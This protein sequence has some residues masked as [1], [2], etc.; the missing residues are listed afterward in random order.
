MAEAL[1]AAT[2]LSNLSDEELMRAEREIA[3]RHL[4]KFPYLITFWGLANTAVWLSLFPLVMMGYVPLWL[5]FIIAT[6]NVMLSYLPSHDAQHDI[7]AR[8]GA[9]LRWLNEFLGHWSLIPL[10]LPFRIARATHMEHHKHANDPELDPDYG[11]HAPNAW[12]A[13]IRSI[14]TRQPGS[15]G[16]L[17]SYGATVQ[18]LGMGHILLDALIA[19]LV[20]YGTLV[21]LAWFGYALEAAL[22]WW[23]PRH[24]AFTYITF[25]LSWA[26]HHPG[27]RTGRY[28]DTRAWR[29]RFGNLWSMGMQYHIIHHLHPRIPLDR[30]PQA[31]REMR[32][33]LIARDCRIENL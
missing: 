3:R 2:D 23:L 29:S 21:A 11:T 6:L 10:V 33:I 24:I 18:R 7:I 9:K 14:T 32:D 22:L 8:P 25:Y 15:K 13:V 16:G 31:Y 19:N 12:M 30:T 28:K 26:P 1:N 5:G 20:F 4:D 27:D 17:K